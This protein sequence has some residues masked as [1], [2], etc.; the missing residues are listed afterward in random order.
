MLRTSKTTRVKMMRPILLAAV[1]WVYGA[2]GTALAVEGRSVA[3]LV[4]GTDLRSAQVPPPE[5]AGSHDLRQHL[6]DRN[7]LRQQRLHTPVE[8]QLTVSDQRRIELHC[9]QVDG[10]WRTNVTTIKRQTASPPR[11][12]KAGWK[13]PE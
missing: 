12:H 8:R 3:V 13:L 2:E 1:M 4:G 10:S 11:G 7:P 5:L 9:C 6:F